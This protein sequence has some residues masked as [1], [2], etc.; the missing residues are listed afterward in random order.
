M[1]PKTTKENQTHSEEKPYNV[2][3]ILYSIKKATKD[4]TEDDIIKMIKTEIDL[5][6]NDLQVWN[7]MIDTISRM[8]LSKCIILNDYLS[9]LLFLS[10]NNLR[11]VQRFYKNRW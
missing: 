10:F 7:R 4:K 1:N 5:S 11:A 2:N 6:E 9:L 8:T 3:R